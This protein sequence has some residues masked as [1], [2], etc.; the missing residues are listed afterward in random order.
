MKT[1][2]NKIHIPVL[3]NEIIANL[4]VKSNGIYIDATA[5][6]GGH[7]SKIASQLKTGKLYCLDQDANAIAHLYNL[8]RD[9][10]Q[11]NIVQTNFSQIDDVVKTNYDVIF[12]YVK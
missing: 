12:N 10:K 4:N 6:F 2:A 8:F 5:G 3:A 7:S 1:T 11:V 9:S